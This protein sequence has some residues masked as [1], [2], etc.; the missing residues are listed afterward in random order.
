MSNYFTGKEVCADA[1][2]LRLIRYTKTR[3]HFCEM[4]VFKGGRPAVVTTLNRAALSGRV[5][6]E[7]QIG[8]YQADVLT[9]GGNSWEQVVALDAKSYRSLKNHWMR[10]RVI[11]VEAA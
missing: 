7:G 8:D 9:E 5:E 11:A 2:G 6:V 4:V 3:A 1:C 10:C